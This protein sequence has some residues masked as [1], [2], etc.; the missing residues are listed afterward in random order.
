M[1]GSIDKSKGLLFCIHDLSQSLRN[2]A[3]AMRKEVESLDANRLLN[4]AP[5]DLRDYLA[6]KYRIEPIRLLRDQW[7]ADTH[8]TQVDV[9]YDS[10]H[11]IDDKSRPFCLS[12]PC[13]AVEQSSA[14][15]LPSQTGR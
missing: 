2:T 7:Y 12:A 6:A 13:R 3:A 5:D 4:T 11:W 8:E 10:N 1:F 15:Q 9:R 14:S